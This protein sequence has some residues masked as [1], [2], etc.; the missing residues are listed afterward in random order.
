M[1]YRSIDLNKIKDKNE[2]NRYKKL[3]KIW[4]LP[5]NRSEKDKEND[6]ANALW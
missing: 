5:D 6:F 4:A 3:K 1:G 2:K